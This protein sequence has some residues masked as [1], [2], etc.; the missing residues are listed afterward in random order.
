M[1]QTCSMIY[2]LGLILFFLWAA[3]E[4]AGFSLLGLMFSFS[5]L[6][7]LADTVSFL[8]IA[9]AF[10]CSV[11]GCA[12]R[13]LARIKGV[14]TALAVF[15]L[16]VNFAIWF[17]PDASGWVLRVLLPLLTFADWLLFDK[18]GMFRPYDPLFWLLG[19]ALLYC[20]WS[21]LAANRPLTVD[22]FSAFFGGKERMVYTILATIAAGALM[23]LLDRICAGKS[24]SKLWD[25]FS[26]CYRILFLCITAWVMFGA[27]GGS[28]LSFFLSLRRYELLFAFL[29]FLCIAVTLIVFV[30]RARSL[31]ASG[32][33]PRIKGAVTASAVL[34]LLGNW[35]MQK[36]SFSVD[37]PVDAILYVAGPLMLIFDW[38]MFDAKGKWKPADPLWWSA[39]PLAYGLILYLCGALFQTYPALLSFGMQTLVVTGIAFVLACGYAVYFFDFC[40]KRK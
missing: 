7:V 14:G 36:G 6:A 40:I 22:A 20:L 26:F 10:I 25:L 33:F 30:F 23:Y 28:L 8:C 1:K 31:R 9:A 21:L 17:S 13:I 35:V 27:C 3:L 5:D 15:V 16:M 2:R 4:N 38:I 18:K 34:I 37:G 19:L 32:P 24:M 29:S 12:P 11:F 39:I